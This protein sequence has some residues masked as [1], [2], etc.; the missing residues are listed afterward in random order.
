MV[1]ELFDALK[2]FEVKLDL[3]INQLKTLPY[4]FLSS[5]QTSN[6]D[7]YITALQD[8][9]TQFDSRFSD[10]RKNEINMNLFARPFNVSVEDAPEE[11]QMEL[12]E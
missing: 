11:V 7:K 12:I 5:C 4:I 10:F 9:K 6:M 2:A 3:W 1:H 8:L